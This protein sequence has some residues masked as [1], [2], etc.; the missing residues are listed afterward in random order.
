MYKFNYTFK[1]LWTVCSLSF[2]CDNDNWLNIIVNSLFNI[3]SKFD[4]DFS[5]FRKESMLSRLNNEKYLEVSSEFLSIFDLSKEM[6]EFSSWYFN[7]LVN[8]SSYWYIE[9]FDNKPKDLVQIKE[10]TNF[11]EIKVF[12]NRIKLL[13]DMNLDF[14][15]IWKWFLADKFKEILISSW[16]KNFIINLWWDIVISW[17]NMNLE[18]S[19]VWIDSPFDQWFICSVRLT[20]K[21]ISTSWTYI[22][23]WEID[24]K[25]YNHIKNPFKNIDNSE[26]VSLSI[27]D[28]YWYKSDCLATWIFNMWFDRWIEF[29]KN[30]NIDGLFIL[31]NRKIVFTD[32]FEKKFNLQSIL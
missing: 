16:Y 22:R 28:N 6:Y 24:N 7:P 29:C 25:I 10:N 17:L 9:S 3:A 18:K 19:V 26:L 2:F 15:A 11:S 4:N 14:W 5:R 13:D 20:D 30:N 31:K 21:S 27:I 32:C 23:S 12:W 8:I 1:A